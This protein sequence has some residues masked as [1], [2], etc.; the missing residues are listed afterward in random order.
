MSSILS[1]LS[2]L[3]WIILLVW[4]AG[5]ITIIISHHKMSDI[6]NLIGGIVS[7]LCFCYFLILTIVYQISG[8]NLF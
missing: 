5:C 1:Q 2:I 4:F 7:L 8:A 6:G 3:S